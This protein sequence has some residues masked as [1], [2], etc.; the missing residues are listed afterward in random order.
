VETDVILK[1]FGHDPVGRT[2]ASGNGL[3]H[4]RALLVTVQ[5]V[6]NR[7]DLA[8]DSPDAVGVLFV[9]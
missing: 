3:E 5:R 9:Q 8:L 1:H 6:L 4:F 7:A 2:A